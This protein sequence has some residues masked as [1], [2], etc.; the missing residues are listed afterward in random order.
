[1]AGWKDSVGRGCVALADLVQL[2]AEEAS[3][4]SVDID[5]LAGIECQGCRVEIRF[6]LA[7]LFDMSLIGLGEAGAGKA[8]GEDLAPL[9]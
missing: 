2:A 6:Q 7:R 5:Q 4:P 8:L 9:A 3:V 1:V